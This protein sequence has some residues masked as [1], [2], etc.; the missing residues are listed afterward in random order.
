MVVINE[1]KIGGGE[2]LPFVV[3]VMMEGCTIGLTILA[4]TAMTSGLSPFVFVVYTNAI[5]TLLLFPFSLFFHWGQ[6]SVLFAC[7]GFLHFYFF[8]LVICRPNYCM[9]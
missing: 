5:G 7:I 2:V 6:R 3:M 8:T 1:L 4:K 9:V